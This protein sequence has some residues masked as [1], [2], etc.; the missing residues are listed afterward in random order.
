MGVLEKRRI[1]LFLGFDPRVVCRG[2]MKNAC[3]VLVRMRQGKGPDE[4]WE[5]DIKTD[6]KT[7]Q[8][9]TEYKVVVYG[10]R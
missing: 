5:H 4:K 9:R 1:L 7:E 8:N 2:K 6:V 3:S 10:R